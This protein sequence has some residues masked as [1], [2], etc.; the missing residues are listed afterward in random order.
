MESRLHKVVSFKL[1]EHARIE[2]VVYLFIVNLQK[3]HIHLNILALFQRLYLSNELLNAPLNKAVRLSIISVLIISD[4]EEYSPLT[5]AIAIAVHGV[6]LTRACLS[7]AENG[8]V[9][10]IDNVLH[11]FVDLRSPVK[12]LLS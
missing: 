6:G 5:L 3:G 1:L 10:P 11:H 8:G 4:G 2:Q 12:I 7:V 9:K